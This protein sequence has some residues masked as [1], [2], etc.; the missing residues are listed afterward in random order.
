MAS[1]AQES[2]T[3]SSSVKRDCRTC[4]VF[5]R[6]SPDQLERSHGLI[7]YGE[8]LCNHHATGERTVR[9]VRAHLRDLDCLI[10]SRARG[11]QKAIPSAGAIVGGER[12]FRENPLRV[13]SQ[14]YPSPDSFLRA[15][16]V[17]AVG[18]GGLRNAGLQ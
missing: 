10:R 3:A 1:A 17:T 12:S 5:S 14:R 13:V 9:H 16:R 2:N 11:D 6:A 18:R 7:D 15:Q 4:E 8:G